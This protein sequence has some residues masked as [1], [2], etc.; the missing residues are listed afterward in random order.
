[1]L[2]T[3][4]NSSPPIEQHPQVLCFMMNDLKRKKGSGTCQGDKPS[5][6][7]SLLL[8]LP[9]YRSETGHEINKGQE[10]WRNSM[11]FC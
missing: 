4:S 5:K 2:T 6:N 3:I 11:Y 10:K 7:I 8:D 9:R 1:M